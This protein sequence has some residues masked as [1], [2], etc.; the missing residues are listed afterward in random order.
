LTGIM[1]DPIPKSVRTTDP[2]SKSVR[3]Y[4]VCHTCDGLCD[5][6]KFNALV[7]YKTD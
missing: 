5:L 3:L 7:K 6:F 2:I 1:T 4:D